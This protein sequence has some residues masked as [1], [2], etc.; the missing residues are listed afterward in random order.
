MWAWWIQWH[1]GDLAEKLEKMAK[2]I[3]VTHLWEHVL[4]LVHQ[5][6]HIKI[7]LEFQL[8]MDVGI[9]AVY[10]NSFQNVPRSQF[11]NTLI[12][13]GLKILQE[14]NQKFIQAVGRRPRISYPLLVIVHFII[15]AVQ[16]RDNLVTDNL[17]CPQHHKEPEQMAR[18]FPHLVEN[19]QTFSWKMVFF[20]GGSVSNPSFSSTI[21]HLFRERYYRLHPQIAQIQDSAVSVTQTD[22]ICASYITSSRTM[23]LHQLTPAEDLALGR[24]QCHLAPLFSFCCFL[25]AGRLFWLTATRSQAQL[26]SLPAP[27]LPSSLDP[28]GTGGVGGEKIRPFRG[29]SIY[30]YW[31]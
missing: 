24:C 8:L 18:F 29:G 5:L 4:S 6:C 16:S 21:H 30:K 28:R 23:T 2:V 15:L 14:Q 1:V 27:S 7:W 20:S 13:V 9:T 26:S 31:L 12:M 11:C 25:S 19:Q 10:S 17:H 22:L 3:L